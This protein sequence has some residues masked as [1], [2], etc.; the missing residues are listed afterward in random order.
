MAPP[1][2]LVAIVD[3]LTLPEALVLA[4]SRRTAPFPG[5]DDFRTRLPRTELNVNNED[6]SIDTQF[7][8]VQGLAKVGKAELRM[9]A[10]VQRSGVTLPSIV[11]QRM[12]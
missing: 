9:Q 6:I 7:F 4:G 8:L 1:E 2:V 5:R 12:S 10:L 3:G 11:W